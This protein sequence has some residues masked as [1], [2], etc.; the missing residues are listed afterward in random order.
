MVRYPVPTIDSGGTIRRESFLGH[1]F[2][3]SV[4]GGLRF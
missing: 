1:D 3:F 2:R 4:G